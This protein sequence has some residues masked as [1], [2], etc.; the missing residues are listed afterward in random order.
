MPNA[1]SKGQTMIGCWC[2]ES[3][4]EKIDKARMGT[5]R[6]QYCRDALSELLKSHGYPVSTT[7]KSP[8]SRIGKGGPKS[9][10]AS[11]KSSLLKMARKIAKPGAHEPKPKPGAS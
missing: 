7:E 11:V 1:R 3:F 4:V 10:S 5:T 2:E 8:P 9:S 6:S